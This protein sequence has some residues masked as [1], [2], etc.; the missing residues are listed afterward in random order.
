MM[1]KG[2]LA[3][4]SLFGLLLTSVAPSRSSTMRSVAGVPSDAPPE[5]SPYRPVALALADDGKLLFVANQR[6]GS[7]SVIDTVSLKVAS[8]IPIGRTVSDLVITPNGKYVLAV[9]NQPG[10]LVVLRRQG[11]R[12]EASLRA[13]VAPFPVSVCVT[14]DGTRCVVASR[15]SRRL[16]L[17]DLSPTGPDGGISAR[18]VKMIDL[19]F[20]PH[21]QLM[22]PQSDKVVV[23]DSFGGRLAVVDLK[24]GDVES[25]RRL[26]AHNIRG[27]TISP[28]R[29]RLFVSH[30]VLNSQ[31]ST[32]RDDLHWGN[33]ISNGVRELKLTSVLDPKV[34][35]LSD[36][37]MHRLGDVGR[38]AGDP[39]GVAA[40]PGGR[41]LV[42]LSGVNEIALGAAADGA[43]QRIKVGNRP[44]AIAVAAEAGRAYVANTFGD[45][46]S[47]LDLKTNEL[48]AEI[49]LG[50]PAKLSVA[51]RGELL[52][53]DA[54]LSHDGWFSC[55]SCHTDGH[56]NGLLV[57]TR[58]DGFHGAPKR[59][60]TL[61]GTKDT[62]PWAWNGRFSELE[63]QIRKSVE[64][65]MQG[66]KPTA[67]QVEEL[68][69]YLQTLAP[70]PALGRTR[71]NMDKTAVRR[72]QEVFGR[73][74]CGKCHITPSYTSPKTYDVGTGDESAGDTLFN[75]PS[76]RAVSQAGPYFHDGRATTLKEV[77]TR[78]RHQLK[79]P[80]EREELEELL[81]FL[82]SL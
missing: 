29:T 69:A 3:C 62:G 22:I 21:A 7:V 43:W 31:G 6:R 82:E 64:T 41:V 47:V 23:A 63:L 53:H 74:Q 56:S 24:R 77:F 19:D 80:L 2:V 45:S 33:L 4:L 25:D 9:D 72:G 73:Q 38:G 16:T 17:V 8:E 39:A 10:E 61:L 34:D 28:D 70:A 18:V 1:P 75:P 57:D 36:S 59:V 48:T 5:R 44:T 79:S 30:Q 54:R 13:P 51:D 49:S 37:R 27:L 14:S 46:V 60:L 12:L 68:V 15:W 32:G 20:A 55:H 71:E 58:G 52:F 65:T 11:A 50:P 81:A 76:L 42:A 78:H 26:P 66:K 35:L 67:G 40:L